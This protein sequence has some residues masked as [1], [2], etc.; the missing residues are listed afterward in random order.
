MD[1]KINREILS[2]NEKIYDGV[3]EQSVELDY[4]L[5]DYFPDIFKLIKCSITPSVLSSAVNGDTVTYELLADIKILYCSENNSGIQCISQKQTYTKTV[6]MGEGVNKPSVFLKPKT[7][8]INCRVVNQRRIDMRGAVSVKVKITG[9]K[10]QEVICDIFGMNA[11]MKK[12]PVEYA[13]KK[14]RENKV[15]SV[16]E[17][18]EMNMSNKPVLSIIRTGTVMSVPDKKII[19]GKLVVKGEVK[20]DILYTCENG[21]EKM[22]FAVPYSQII[23]MEGLDESY[24]CRVNTSVIS[25]DIIPAADS[26][27]EMKILKCELKINIECNAEKSIP[28][29]L[30]ADAYSTSYPCEYTSSRLMVEQSPLEIND[31]LQ[32]KISVEN[33]GGSVSAVYDVWCSI[34]NVNVRII[35]DEKSISISGMLCC[36]VMFKGDNNMPSVME[37][38]EAFERKLEYA[39]ITANSTADIEPEVMDCSYTLTSSSGI[40][41]KAEI[42]ISGNLYTSSGIEAITDINFNDT[43]KIVRDGDYAL[44]LYYGVQN[45]DIWDIAKKYYTSVKAIMEENSLESERLTDN[46]MLLIPIV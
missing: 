2:V 43:T 19:A 18:V 21:M 6:Q 30:V 13:A 14:I 22:Q 10:N 39:Q 37:K 15:I 40:S 1:L 23:D 31:V 35:P 16:S 42:R 34:K 9:E 17:D 45:E 41:V 38:E 3:Q 33:E 25:C 20:A 24:Q 8:H 46:G 5:P 28:V 26:D 4:I 44:K 27:G 36:N 32:E 29:Q 7:D 12:I 11:Q